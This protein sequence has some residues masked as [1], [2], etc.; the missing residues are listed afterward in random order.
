MLTEYEIQQIIDSESIAVD[1]ETTEVTAE[2]DA[3]MFLEGALCGHRFLQNG[4]MQL[5]RIGE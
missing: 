4:A 3:D 1:L 2:V 5:F